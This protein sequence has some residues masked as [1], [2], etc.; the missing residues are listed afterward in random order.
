MDNLSEHVILN[1]MDQHLPHL[2]NTW[3]RELSISIHGSMM[4]TTQ[5]FI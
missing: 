2:Q 3:I 4:K 1:L 5:V